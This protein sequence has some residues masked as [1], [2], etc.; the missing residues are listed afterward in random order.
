VYQ[1]KSES[2]VQLPFDKSYYSRALWIRELLLEL[3]VIK[4]Y[5]QAEIYP[6]HGESCYTYFRECEY[7]QT[8]TLSTERLTSSLT[9][10]AEVALD[11]QLETFQISIGIE[12]LIKAQISKDAMQHTPA[13][14]TAEAGDE[15]I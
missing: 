6:M 15:F 5:E 8:C 9:A 2:F 3:E 10:A 11:A 12:D 13:L 14:V 7:L 4:L 1:T